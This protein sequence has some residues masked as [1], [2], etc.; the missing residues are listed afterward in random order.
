[1]LIMSGFLRRMNVRD[2]ILKVQFVFN[3]LRALLYLQCI[4]A[5]GAVR[6]L[7]FL[8]W[9]SWSTGKF[10]SYTV[11][12]LWSQPSLDCVNHRGINLL[13][14]LLDE[15]LVWF[16]DFTMYD[17]F[18]SCH[19]GL[20]SSSPLPHSSPKPHTLLTELTTKISTRLINIILIPIHFVNGNIIFSTLLE[21]FSIRL[22]ILWFLRNYPTCS[23]ALH[24]K[25][26]RLR[27]HV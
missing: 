27:Q 13:L 14:T 11:I 24:A 2:F 3:K 5:I 26:K 15:G 16:N 17:G 20:C 8:P 12:R 19:T 7:A 22:P 1:M 25:E 10:W 18:L 6:P 4:E 23:R 21:S 9:C